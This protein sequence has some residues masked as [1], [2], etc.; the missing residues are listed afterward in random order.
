MTVEAWPKV[1]S[2]FGV[3]GNMLTTKGCHK[4]APKTGKMESAEGNMDIVMAYFIDIG[5]DIVVADLI[6]IGRYQ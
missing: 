1:D 4:N 2:I 6:D 5:V 3:L